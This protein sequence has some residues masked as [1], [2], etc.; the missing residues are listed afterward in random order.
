MPE[1]AEKKGATNRLG[2]RAPL[3]IAKPGPSAGSQRSLAEALVYRPPP[4]L[5]SAL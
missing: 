2:L 4:G 3:I 5:P 1:G